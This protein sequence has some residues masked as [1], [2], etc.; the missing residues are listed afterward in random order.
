MYSLRNVILV[1]RYLRAPLTVTDTHV[2]GQ[3]A[4]VRGGRGSDSEWGVLSPTL[5]FRS[6][7]PL[8]L[9][10]CSCA[11]IF[12]V[13]HTDPIFCLPETGYVT[14]YLCVVARTSFT[15]VAFINCEFLGFRICVSM[16]EFQ[17]VKSTYYDGQSFDFLTPESK[18]LCGKLNSTLS[19]SRN[20]PPFMEPEGSLPCS[21]EP[22]TGPYPEPDESN[23]HPNPC[24]PKIHFNIIPPSTHRSSDWSIPLRL[25]N[26]HL[27]PSCVLHVPPISSSLIWSPEQYMVKISLILLFALWI[28][29]GGSML[30]T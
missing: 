21:Q 18:V 8:L 29:A 20:P 24:A 26:Q 27:S 6:S 12:C 1:A 11:Q 13:Q 14:Y 30:N 2:S 22:S 3:P 15:S 16:A 19:L 17:S 7:L 5:P 25:S 4:E 28:V 23:P 9:W 10:L